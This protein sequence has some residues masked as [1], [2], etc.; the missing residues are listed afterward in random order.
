MEDLII[1]VWHH[2]YS[3]AAMNKMLNACYF[4]YVYVCM[5][6]CAYACSRIGSEKR[7]CALLSRW[8]TVF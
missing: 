6:L 3:I 4:R 7:D 8:L 5:C 2:N 1:D